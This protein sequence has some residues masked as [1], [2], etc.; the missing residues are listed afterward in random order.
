MVKNAAGKVAL[1]YIEPAPHFEHL[2]NGHE[3]VFIVKKAISLA[4]VEEGDVEALLGI[5]GGCCGG[6]QLIYRVASEAQV[7]IWES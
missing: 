2:P 4:W 6:K 1:F 7:R 5:H 3:Y